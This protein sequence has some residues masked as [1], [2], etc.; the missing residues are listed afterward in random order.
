MYKV[1][2]LL[3]YVTS[4]LYIHVVIYFINYLASKQV[5]NKTFLIGYLIM[6]KVKWVCMYVGT[7]LG[8]VM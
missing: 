7:S 2:S 5:K 6:S 8:E 1:T 4:L 3:R